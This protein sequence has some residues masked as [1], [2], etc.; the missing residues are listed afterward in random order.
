[1][2]AVAAMVLLAPSGQAL[3]DP[4]ESP[5]PFIWGL[6]AS[7]GG[8]YDDVRMCIATDPGVKGG[9]AAV[10]EQ[11]RPKKRTRR[12][13]LQA[14]GA[15]LAA[16]ALAGGGYVIYGRQ[17]RF[18]REAQKTIMDHRV[19][20]PAASPAMVIA[21]GPSPKANVRA[22]LQR[23]GGMKLLVKPSDTVLVK[24]NIGWDRRP[25]NAAN[26]QPEVV[27]ELVRACR[28]AGARKVIVCDCPVS[29]A[30]KSFKRSGILAAA[31][32]AGAKVIMP[33][34]SRYL[35][36]KISDRLGTWEVLEPFFEATKIINVPVAK[37][38]ALIGFSGGMKNWFG[39]TTKLR[40]ILH[41]DLQRSIAELGALMRPTLTVLDA[42]LVLMRNGPQGG[43]LADVKQVNTVAASVDP[44][45]IDAWAVTQ[46][47]GEKKL[48]EYL[49]LAQ[50]MGLGRTDYKALSPVEITA[51]T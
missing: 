34:Q 7:G 42:S 44:V 6:K 49:G 23:M 43:S 16:G 35:T 1:M 22:V 31:H 50:G 37:H 18:G 24:P 5:A 29:K 33:E 26:T 39:I 10:A 14:G 9:A 45:A 13:V 28:D 4:G 38:H 30:R 3:A 40:M 2:A 51:G 47:G 15:L 11:P 17:Q 41:N 12:R 21:Q 46:L 36:V 25:K 8:R 27:A 32:E 48:P 20:L 19:K